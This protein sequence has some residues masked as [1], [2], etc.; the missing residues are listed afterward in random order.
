M[1]T[2]AR[3][4]G[5]VGIALLLV[6]SVARADFWDCSD[7]PAADQSA[8]VAAYSRQCASIGSFRGK[9]ACKA[10]VVWGF[11][12]PHVCRDA[13]FVEACPRAEHRGDP[14]AEHARTISDPAGWQSR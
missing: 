2:A 8:C 7:L 14:R 4:G 6:S 12:P 10:R 1:A 9:W 11:L 13:A 5:M 3:W